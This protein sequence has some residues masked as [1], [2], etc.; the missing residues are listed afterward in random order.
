MIRPGHVAVILA[1]A[2]MLAGMMLTNPDYN[3]I[4]RPFVSHAGP[5]ES[6]ATRLIEGR[7]TG[8]RTA[9]AIAFTDYSGDKLRRT[10]GVFLIAELTLTGRS[11]ST[12]VAAEWVG[13]SGRHYATTSRV[14]GLRQQIEDV[15]LQPGLDMKAIAIF[16]LPPDELEGGAVLLTLRLN[17]PLDGT[18]LLDA[19]TDPAPH[20]AVARFDG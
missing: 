8:W 15:W 12:L 5:G 6:G 7:L 18:I 14:S 17:P 10:D 13:A 16:E 4:V 1:A 3:S 2:V 19:P 9:D 20:E 11:T